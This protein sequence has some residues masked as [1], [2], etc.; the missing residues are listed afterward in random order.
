MSQIGSGEHGNTATLGSRQSLSVSVALCT[1]QGGRYLQEQLES[2][3]TQSTLPNEIV[4][5][6]D[7]SKDD[8]LEQ[9]K[10]FAGRATERGIKVTVSGNP[11]NLGY[12]KNFTQALLAAEGDLIFLCDQDDVWH[13]NKL[14]R[15]AEEFERRP[16][17]LMLHSNA[18]LVDASGASLN[19]TV[20]EA[21]EVTRDELNAIHDGE[22]FKV[23]VKRNVATGATM[24][25]RRS[26][27]EK[28]FEVPSGWIH[29]EWLAM[30]AATQGRVDCLEE[31]TI[32]YRQH[33]KNQVGARPRGIMER[34][35][36]GTVTRTAFMARL[37]LRTQSLTDQAAAGHIHLTEPVKHMLSE[38]LKHAQLRAYLPQGVAARTVAVLR[39]YASGRYTQFSNGIKS[40]LSDISKIRG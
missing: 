32:D 6:D 17:L 25:I 30:L 37:L 22:A 14:R 10:T 18:A 24:A 3:L 38:R 11:S 34:I 12:V 31:S 36:G 28:G 40:V 33:D 16:D 5:F 26:V 35:T 13:P 15:F 9:L 21:F 20:F 39:E 29:D 4:A 1:Y 8:T 7:V 2:L 27:I 23:L 19:R